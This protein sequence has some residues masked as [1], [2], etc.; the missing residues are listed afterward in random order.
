MPI[1]LQ[2]TSFTFFLTSSIIE[3]RFISIH[4]QVVKRGVSSSSAADFAQSYVDSGPEPRRKRYIERSADNAE[5]LFSSTNK[6]FVLFYF[7]LFFSLSLLIISSIEIEACFCSSC[8][9]LLF[10]WFFLFLG[11]I[12]QEKLN[13]FVEYLFIS[14]KLI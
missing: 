4:F 11:L 3:L 8:F 1:L 2:T 7:I 5:D 13:E 6:R 14:S 10:C 12:Q 9:R